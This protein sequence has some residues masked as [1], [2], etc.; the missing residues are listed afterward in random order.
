MKKIIFLSAIAMFSASAHAQ[1]ASFNSHTLDIHNERNVPRIISM[2]SPVY[3]TEGSA[4]QIIQKAQG[5]V[6]R[7]VVNDEVATSGSSASGYFGAIA[8][9]GHNVNSSVAGGSLIELSD[10]A[11]G[12]LIANSRADFKFMMIGHSVRSRLTVEAKEG[13]FRFVHSNIESLQKNTGYMRNDGYSQIIQ[14]KGTG[15]DKALE[16]VSG[17]EEKIVSCMTNSPSESW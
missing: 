6:V 17:V 11:N 2:T 5:C 7:N 10:P 12:L 8:G 16:A 13:R 1:E 14:R 15:W 3:Q 4:E 9:Q